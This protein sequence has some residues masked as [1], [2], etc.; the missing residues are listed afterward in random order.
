MIMIAGRQ[1]INHPKIQST[2][3]YLAW[4]WI[5]APVLL[6]ATIL[7]ALQA[8]WFKPNE[9]GMRLLAVVVVTFWMSVVTN[10]ID[11]GVRFILRLK[12]SGREY[13]RVS[14][15]RIGTLWITLLLQGAIVWKFTQ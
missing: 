8:S 1:S 12:T 9:S 14:P 3:R 2:A 7:L 10:L 5:I 4:S 11:L 6:A 13:R 15:V